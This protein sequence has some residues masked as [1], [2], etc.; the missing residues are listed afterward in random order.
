MLE[1]VQPLVVER[2]LV[3]DGQVP[4]VEV[5]R[6]QRQRDRPGARA[7]RSQRMPCSR[8]T[9]AMTGPVRPSTSSSAA[10]SAISRC[11]TMWAA[12]SSPASVR[13]GGEVGADEHEQAGQEA[14][15]RASRDGPPRGRERAHPHQVRD[16]VREDDD[17]Q[18]DRGGS[19]RSL[20]GRGRAIDPQTREDPG[21]PGRT[22]DEVRRALRRPH[23]AQARR[24]GAQLRAARRGPARASPGCC[25][26][27]ASRSATG[28]GSCSRTSRTSR[29]S[30][31]ACCAP[32]ASS[33]R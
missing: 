9:G 13:S 18:G 23:R 6:P 17:R 10:P 27:R 26:R 15:D 21:E 22:H 7:T 12:N 5:E 14:G 1:R 28:S 25:T 2:A 24:R 19:E 8:R 33:S 4:H 3:E 16:G 11:S 20:S 30:T 32:A 31:T 29:S